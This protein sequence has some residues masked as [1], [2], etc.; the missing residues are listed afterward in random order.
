MIKYKIVDV[1]C[2]AVTLKTEEKGFR[3]F[4]LNDDNT[5]ET[6]LTVKDS[7]VSVVDGSGSVEDKGLEDYSYNELRSLAKKYDSVDGRLG[8]ETL[9]KKLKEVGAI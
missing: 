9:Y 2:G 6:D 8:K 4:S 5:F 7:R 3:T 1:S